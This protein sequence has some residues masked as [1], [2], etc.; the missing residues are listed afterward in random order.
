MKKENLLKSRLARRALCSIQIV[1]YTIH[2]SVQQVKGLDIPPQDTLY[3]LRR[4]PTLD[5]SLEDANRIIFSP[6]D[7]ISSFEEPVTD[8][9]ID[10]P[11][12]ME[13]L[14]DGE[15]D[16]KN[17]EGIGPRARPDPVANKLNISTDEEKSNK[18]SSFS[19]LV[20]RVQA[21]HF[22]K[23]SFLVF[24]FFLIKIFIFLVY[25]DI[26]LDSGLIRTTIQIG[27]IDYLSILSC[28][29]LTQTTH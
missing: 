14:A 28:A 6:W 7:A 26:K 19:Q 12:N 10:I 11:G 27:N 17:K 5:A 21:A 13:V 9:V 8:S 2:Y 1:S 15:S 25:A 3:T 4:K 23:V 22:N 24:I 18:S 20:V 29:Y 16:W